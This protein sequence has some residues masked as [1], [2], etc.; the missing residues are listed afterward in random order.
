MKS[1]PKLS[2]CSH[3]N[4]T[5]PSYKVKRGVAGRVS[6]TSWYRETIACQN[7]RVEITARTPGNAVLA[8]NRSRA[9]RE[10]ERAAALATIPAP[11]GAEAR[12]VAWHKIVKNY[13]DC[14]NSYG[15]K[16]PYVADNGVTGYKSPWSE[17]RELADAAPSAAEAV[18]KPLE[19][20]EQMF[21]SDWFA[22]TVV[23][24][25]G[26]GVVH[27]AHI[28]TLR[29]INDGQ[30]DDVVFARG[31]EL[32]EAKAAAQADY[33]ARIRSALVAPASL[34]V[35]QIIADIRSGQREAFINHGEQP[36]DGSLNCPHCGGSG[37]RDDVVTPASLPDGWRTIDSAPRN[38]TTFLA[39]FPLP[40]L[41]DDWDRIVPVYWSQG[42]NR[43]VFAGRAA[44]GYSDQYQPTHWMPLPA[45][46]ANAKG[47]RAD[48]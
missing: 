35:E 26:V 2:A 9:G 40:G 30:W 43:W 22:N 38:G 4:A 15:T 21:G 20:E 19:W 17:L 28:A 42:V 27:D 29:F 3:C 45:A 25:Y 39:Y 5:G 23:G 32:E 16:S 37:H 31:L 33:E 1:A 36:N 13:V 24:T 48:G 34:D 47:E 18:V 41:D 12:P 7:C 6:R 8:W 14:C 46:P 11:A 10:A 44:A